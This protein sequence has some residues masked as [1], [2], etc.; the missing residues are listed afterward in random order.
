MINKEKLKLKT[1][2]K[3]PRPKRIELS[4]LD[5]DLDRWFS[6]YTR[7]KNSKDG[8]YATCVTCGKTQELKDMDNGHY[9]SRARKATKFTQR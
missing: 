6:K 9:I 3:K 8:I 4:K 2:L 7:L 5:A 1:R